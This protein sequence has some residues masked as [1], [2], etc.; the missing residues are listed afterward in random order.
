[1]KLNR[2]TKLMVT[3]KIWIW[4]D[5][6]FLDTSLVVA[7]RKIAV[8]NIFFKRVQ[9]CN[10]PNDPKAM[11]ME[12]NTA[13]HSCQ[14]TGMEGILLSIATG[15]ATGERKTKF[16]TEDSLLLIESAED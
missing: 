16:F 11:Q 8:L 3:S 5:G 13:H 6:F 12:G 1:M 14:P 7:Q 10:L 2:K 9:T 4:K 15:N